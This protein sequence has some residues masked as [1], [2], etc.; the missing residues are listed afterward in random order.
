MK[1]VIAVWFS[2]GA[3]SAVAAKLTLE[4]YSDTHEIRVLN[5]PVAEEDEDN[6]RFLHDVETWLGVKIETVI[7]PMFPNA[8]AVEVWDHQKYMSGVAGAPCT[9]ALK[10][11]ARLHW[12]K[13]NHVDAIVLGFTADEQRRADLF[14]KNERQTLIPVLIDAGLTV[15]MCY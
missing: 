8:S 2:C 14:T 1:P 7:N 11:L 13:H 5:N 12:E 10:K 15:S 3:A 9:K 4:K 6:I